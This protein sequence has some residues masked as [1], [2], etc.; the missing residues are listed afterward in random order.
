M[1]EPAAYWRLAV[2]FDA[3]RGNRH[4]LAAGL[5]EADGAMRAAARGGA[6]RFGVAERFMN[7]MLNQGQDRAGWRRNDGAVEVTVGASRSS[8]LPVIAAAL[9]QVLQPHIDLGSTE[10]MAGPSYFMV[11]PR[12]GA[13]VL[14]L[15]F[16][17]DPAKTKQDFSRWW[18]YQHSAIAIPMLGSRL[19]AY[20]QV[21]CDDVLTAAVSSAFGVPAH[22]YDAYDNLTWANLESFL[23]PRSDPEGRK[24]LSED[25]IGQIDNSSRRHAI[26]KVLG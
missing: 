1:I 20:D 2:I 8:E 12:L 23:E 25:S 9:R 19:L 17:R 14:S 16:K 22:Y 18:Y 6:I 21:H 24:R 3:P 7:D 5:V 13:C 15:S 26:L 11:P 10:V 4:E